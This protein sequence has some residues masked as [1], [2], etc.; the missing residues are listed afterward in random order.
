M[1]KT[2][3]HIAA[4]LLIAMLVL[5]VLAV[6]APTA[7]AWS[8]ESSISIQI[9][10]PAGW[11]NCDAIVSVT[12]TDNTGDGFEKAMVNDNGSWRDITAALEQQGRQY[13]AVMTVSDNCIVSAS[14]TGWDGQTYEKSQYIGCF[15]RTAPTLRTSFTDSQLHVETA[16]NIS[17]VAAVYVDGYR[18][19]VLDN[20]AVDVPLI[21]IG[22]SAAAVNIQA[23][24]YAGNFSQ[25]VTEPNPN[26]KSVSSEP[27]TQVSSPQKLVQTTGPDT[28]VNRPQ[29]PVSYPQLR[30][31]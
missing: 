11:T 2:K 21:E 31:H 20:G 12:I 25:T 9:A 22:D 10:A 29:I 30:E 4:I 1:W 23:E 5:S 28:Q 18:Y 8:E 13:H 17:G 24:D 3:F 27:D 14:V 19:I 7:L 16:D 15:D 6:F 26:Y